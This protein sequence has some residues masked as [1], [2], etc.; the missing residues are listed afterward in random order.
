MTRSRRTTRTNPKPEGLERPKRPST[1]PPELVRR[2][3]RVVTVS[4]AGSRNPPLVLVF[5]KV[6]ELDEVLAEVARSTV[7]APPGAYPMPARVRE[8]LEHVR[9]GWIP[10]DG[11]LVL[12]SDGI[13][14][15]LDLVFAHLLKLAVT[16]GSAWPR[17]EF[18]HEGTSFS[19]QLVRVSGEDAP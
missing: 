9:S 6:P 8:G 5:R 3:L 12:A 1:A 16:E 19:F 2:W 15:C 10:R 17:R 13:S 4:L 14:V 18:H 7:D 11:P